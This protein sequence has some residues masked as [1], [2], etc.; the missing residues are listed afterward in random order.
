MPGCT[1][2]PRSASTVR[3]VPA[4]GLTTRASR[5]RSSISPI[6]AS[7]LPGLRGDARG[8]LADGSRPRAVAC[9]IC[10]A[11]HGDLALALVQLARRRGFVREE[12]LRAGELFA[13]RFELR[14]ESSGLRGDLWLLRERSLSLRQQALPLRAERPPLEPELRRVDQPDD[15]AF[16]EAVA[17]VY[18]EPEEAA[19]RLG[20]DGDLGRF[21]VAVGV[22]LV[23]VAAATEEHEGDQHAEEER[24]DVDEYMSA[25]HGQFRSRVGAAGAGGSGKR[26]S[27]ERRRACA[28]ARSMRWRASVSRASARS[29]RRS[30]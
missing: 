9:S 16:G 27:A 11:E 15:G 23:A 30:V 21:E 13:C 29:V 4:V 3:T 17:L 14:S 22:G 5:I 1:V 7:S 24:A 8:L 12:P 26:P 20:R 19:L 28:W 25:S 6:C 2:S 18:V 10:S